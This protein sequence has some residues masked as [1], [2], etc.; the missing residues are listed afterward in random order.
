VIL[1]KDTQYH[2]LL[3]TEDGKQRHLRFD[4]SRQSAMYL[5]DPYE[6]SFK[7]PRYLHLALAVK[8]DP[9]RVLIVGLGV[10]RS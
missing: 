9:K 4:R 8:P 7:Y 10:A 5:D 2:H 1:E 6:S 3:V